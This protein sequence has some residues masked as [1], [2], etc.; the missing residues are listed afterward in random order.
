MSAPRGI[1][2]GAMATLTRAER[3][4]ALREALRRA[5]TIGP[6][7]VPVVAG[8]GA[9]F[10]VSFAVDAALY[11]TVGT[12]WRQF[13][14]AAAFALVAAPVW[15]V[16]QRP[17]VRHAHEVMTWLNGW[18]TERW[19]HEV[20]RRLPGLPRS[21]P[22]ILEAL[23]DTMGLRPLRIELLAVRGDL[24]EAWDRLERLPT[25]TPW[26]RFERVA[27]E[28]WISFMSNGPEHVDAMSSAA[29]EVT[30]ERSL[31]ARAMVAAA[32]ARRAAVGGG[33]VIGPLASLRP[34]LGERPGRYAF[35]YRTGVI[36]SVVIIALIASVA[37]TVAAAVIR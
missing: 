12:P 7:S 27:L 29:P 32:R 1:L 25:D 24:D 30:D 34:E 19:Q 3:L 31:V 36:L 11:D 5:Q 23:P 22:E 14:N 17:A 20:G 18:E 13:A 15:L 26:Q 35:P 10:L 6:F 8:I 9:G 37:V 2:H 28:E 33:D 21:T 4:L 16:V